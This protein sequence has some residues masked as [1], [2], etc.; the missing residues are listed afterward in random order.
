VEIGLGRG[1]NAD[2]KKLGSFNA[3]GTL[4]GLTVALRTTRVYEAFT[5]EYRG[6]Y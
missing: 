3:N 1:V 4:S 6:I 2:R 5:Y